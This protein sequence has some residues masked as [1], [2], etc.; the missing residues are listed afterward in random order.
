MN[1]K[2]K[3]TL[4][5]GQFS[6]A[7]RTALSNPLLSRKARKE[8]KAALLAVTRELERRMRFL[9][10]CERQTKE[11]LEGELIGAPH[12]KNLSNRLQD[13]IRVFSRSKDHEFVKL[14]Q[15][16]KKRLEKLIR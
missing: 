3:P 5:L 11:A 2:T 13:A 15:E 14:F 16:A 7:M 6:R 12:L 9:E 10:R 1:L 4:S 8:A